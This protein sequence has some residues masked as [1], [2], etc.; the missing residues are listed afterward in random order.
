MR[1]RTEIAKEVSRRALAA[2]EKAEQEAKK[3]ADDQRKD[4]SGGGLASLTAPSIQ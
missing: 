1:H 4:E 3:K 2:R